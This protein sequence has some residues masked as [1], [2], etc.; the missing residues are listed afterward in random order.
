MTTGTSTLP[1]RPSQDDLVEAFAAQWGLLAEEPIDQALFEGFDGAWEH[2]DETELSNDNALD[3][4]LLELPD[5]LEMPDFDNV[6]HDTLDGLHFEHP[7]IYAPGIHPQALVDNCANPFVPAY[8]DIILPGEAVTQD[9]PIH[10]NEANGMLQPVAVRPR[11][12]PCCCT[13]ADQHRSARPEPR[14]DARLAPAANETWEYLVENA[15]QQARNLELEEKYV[16]AAGQV[17]EEQCFVDDDEA[18]PTAEC[19]WEAYHRIN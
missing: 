10:I 4:L 9:R 6:N 1:P 14:V 15:N 2:A 18:L 12:R 8:T 7:P 5:D 17:E 16:V 3:D 13:S 11:S 19:L